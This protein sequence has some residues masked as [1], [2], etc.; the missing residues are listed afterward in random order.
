MQE[1]KNP[2]PGKYH[3]F[4]CFGH[5]DSPRWLD[6]QKCT[7]NKKCKYCYDQRG[8]KPLNK[9]GSNYQSVLNATISYYA[10]QKKKTKKPVRGRDFS[11]LS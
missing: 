1:P 5:K 9:D 7:N 6:P 3:H 2:G 4:I 10:K 8:I 11:S